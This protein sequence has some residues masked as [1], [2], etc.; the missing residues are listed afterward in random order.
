[1]NKLFKLNL[2]LLLFGF[3]VISAAA[4]RNSKMRERK[5]IA[6]K[7]VDDFAK[8]MAVSF[9]SNYCN[10]SRHKEIEAMNHLKSVTTPEEFPAA[11]KLAVIQSLVRQTNVPNFF[12]D[13]YTAAN[14]KFLNTF[15]E[16]NN[17]EKQD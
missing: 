15:K 3:S 7:A 8:A 13:Q 12:Q 1:M 5:R 6:R 9:Y 17:K 10:D 4:E 2:L 14:A 11:N 16:N